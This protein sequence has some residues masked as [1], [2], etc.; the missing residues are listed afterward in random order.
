MIIFTSI[1]Q[2]PTFQHSQQLNLQSINSTLFEKISSLKP[3]RVPSCNCQKSQCQKNY[4]ECYLSHRRCSASC[5]CQNCENQD[6]LLEPGKLV[7]FDRFARLEKRGKSE[8]QCQT[9]CQNGYCICHKKGNK[10]RVECNCSNCNNIDS[11][12]L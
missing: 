1:Q 4:C 2:F 11:I 12:T 3:S 5:G 9:G 8:C 7:E 6:D 10:C